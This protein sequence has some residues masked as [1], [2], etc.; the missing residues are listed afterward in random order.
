MDLMEKEAERLYEKR[1]AYWDG[2]VS[3]AFFVSIVAWIAVI[4]IVFVS[5]L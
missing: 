4:S 2:F 1:L 3:G 5:N